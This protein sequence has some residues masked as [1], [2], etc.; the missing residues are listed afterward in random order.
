MDIKSR[1]ETICELI[2]IQLF[3]LGYITLADVKKLCGCPQT[4]ITFLDQIYAIVQKEDG[5]TCIES[6]KD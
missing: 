4:E 1:Y 5:S 2:D 3:V 6:L